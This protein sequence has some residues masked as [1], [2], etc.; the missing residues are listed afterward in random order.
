MKSN[1]QIQVPTSGSETLLTTEIG[2]LQQTLDL[3]LGG[4]AWIPGLAVWLN[5]KLAGYDDAAGME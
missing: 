2:N 3:L 5:L 1:P 4:R